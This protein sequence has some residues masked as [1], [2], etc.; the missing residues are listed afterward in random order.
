MQG[1]SRR[2]PSVAAHSGP[3]VGGSHSSPRSRKQVVDIAFLSSDNVLF[4]LSFFHC[5]RTSILA[6][7]FARFKRLEG[8]NVHYLTGTDEHGLKI[9]REA[10]K[11]IKIP[12][13][14]VMKF[15]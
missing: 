2:H 4:T 12:R 14:F 7:I 1:G 3:Y 5:E 8:Y 11:I 10:K 13:L 9:E 6:D 15:Q